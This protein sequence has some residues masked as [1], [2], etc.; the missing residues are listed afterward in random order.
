[1]AGVELFADDF[2]K[3]TTVNCPH[4]TYDFWNKLY[5]TYIHFSNFGDHE[6]LKL[7]YHDD[8]EPKTFRDLYSVCINKR[9]SDD[10]K[11]VKLL[12]K[13]NKK[14]L[15]RIRLLIWTLCVETAILVALL[16]AW[17]L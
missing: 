14:R 6:L 7:I 4:I 15:K 2:I 12:Y 3:L 16:L 13:K 5:H 8:I 1:M 10:E 11:E 9:I 17:L